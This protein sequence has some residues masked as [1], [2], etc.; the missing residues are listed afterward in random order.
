MEGIS[1]CFIDEIDFEHAIPLH[2]VFLFV[3]L[4][5]DIGIQASEPDSMPASA[6]H[7]I[8]GSTLIGNYHK[9]QQ[10]F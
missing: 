5:E 2:L 6:V 9:Y 4:T 10:S 1:T 8:W 7:P 3:I